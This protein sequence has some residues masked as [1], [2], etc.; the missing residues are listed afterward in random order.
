LIKYIILIFKVSSKLPLHI[1]YY[2]SGFSIRRKNIWLLGCWEGMKFRGN[3]R[4]FFEYLR[5]N[6]PEIDSRWITKNYQLYKTLQN[7]GL[8]V[9]YAYNING[10]ITNLIAKYIFV[11]HGICD[12][13]QYLSRNAIISDFSHALCP[14]KKMGFA[15]VSTDYYNPSSLFRKLYYWL[16][17]PYGYK[18]PDFA[19][20]SSKYTAKLGKEIFKI[21]D[22]RVCITGLP[23]TDYLFTNIY[24]NPKVDSVINKHVEG[25]ECKNVILFLPTFRNDHNFNLFDFKFDLNSLHDILNES[26]SFLFFN[27]HPFDSNRFRGSKEVQKNSRIVFLNF[28]GDEINYLLKKADVL[29][30]DYGSLWSDFLIF[31]KPMIFANFDHEKY[32]KERELFSNCFNE[33]P[34]SKAKNWTELLVALKNILVHGEDDYIDIRGVMLSKL[35]KYTDNNSCKRI[36]NHVKTLDHV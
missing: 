31:N 23:K 5:K 29:I 14:I 4:F 35:Y 33:L 20:F 10:I 19:F 21:E 30:S 34:G 2:L 18:K 36:L 25:T 11:T 8:N 12:V 17:I 9:F 27:L 32:I 28:K 15:A 7:E 26:K 16:Y 1:I 24:I 13:N 22:E 6:H 3:S